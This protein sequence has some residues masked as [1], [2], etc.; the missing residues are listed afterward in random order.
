MWPV[1]STFSIRSEIKLICS[2]SSI[3]GDDDN[4]N[5]GRT[6]ISSE[7]TMLG[8]QKFLWSINNS[9]YFSYLSLV[10]K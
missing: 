9:N 10:M 7:V 6:G 8:Q 5:L 4:D 2:S 1:W 3:D